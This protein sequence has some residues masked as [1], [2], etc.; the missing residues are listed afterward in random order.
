VRQAFEDYVSARGGRLLRFAYLL[1]GDAH[2]AEDLVQEALTRAHRHWDRIEADDPDAYVRATLVRTHLSWW[3]RRSNRERVTA[4]PPHHPGP[5]PDFADVHAV[6]DE[7][8]RLLAG[9]PRAQRAVLV[10]RFFEDL[11]D[12]RIATVLGC[13]PGTVRV[14]ASR[15]LAA[16][17]AALPASLALNGDAR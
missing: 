6:R 10:L 11:D 4:D 2:L 3:R 13:A 12:H 7:L 5:R 16:M 8:W 9:L 14:H 15:G 17:R 1:C